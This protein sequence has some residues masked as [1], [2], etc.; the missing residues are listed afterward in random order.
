MSVCKLFPSAMG[1]Q[2]LIT[3][4]CVLVLF[5]TKESNT[6]ALSM[7]RERKE[8][9]PRCDWYEARERPALAHQ[10]KLDEYG[11]PQY[12]AGD[13]V[14]D[15][16][17]CQSQIRLAQMQ[18]FQGNGSVTLG[19]F[20]NQVNYLSQVQHWE[21]Q[22]TCH[23][24]CAHQSWEKRNLF[25]VNYVR[26]TETEA[27]STFT[28]RAAHAE[29]FE[30]CRQLYQAL[31]L[32]PGNFG[33]NHNTATY[34]LYSSESTKIAMDMQMMENMVWDRLSGTTYKNSMHQIYVCL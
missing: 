17:R 26:A 18:G 7:V 11:S 3:T 10:L 20:S 22:E 6:L 19:S 15:T 5:I 23:R 14:P 30:K 32:D 24:D 28:V 12:P 2:M 4:M 29:S 13:W 8:W 1:T 31:M 27:G 25:S 34:R 16:C 21:E 9:L 33:A